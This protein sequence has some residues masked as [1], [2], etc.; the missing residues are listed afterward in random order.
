MRLY[1]DDFRTLRCARKTKT[2]SFKLFYLMLIIRSLGLLT[3]HYKY[4]ICFQ[5]NLSVF[6]PEQLQRVYTILCFCFTKSSTCEQQTEIA[7]YFEEFPLDK[8]IQVDL[9]VA[10]RY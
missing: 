4:A 10:S 6:E 9:I 7:K 5:C 1:N 3:A 2:V 8:W